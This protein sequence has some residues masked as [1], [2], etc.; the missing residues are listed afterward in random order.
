MNSE[1]LLQQ[2]SLFVRFADGYGHII[3]VFDFGEFSNYQQLATAFAEAFR[4]TQIVKSQSSRKSLFNSLRQWFTYL[5][6]LPIA[7]LK[8]SDISTLLIRG[9]IEWL[10]RHQQWNIV[11]KQK[12]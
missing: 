12:K 5:N 8:I 7:I 10:N 1:N 3:Q 2:D 4:E 6:E 11:T 9:Y